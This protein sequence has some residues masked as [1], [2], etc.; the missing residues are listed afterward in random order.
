MVLYIVRSADLEMRHWILHN[1]PMVLFILLNTSLRYSSNDKRLPDLIP[2]C[3]CD[4]LINSIVI[5]YQNRMRLFVNFSTELAL[6]SSSTVVCTL[7]TTENNK[8]HI[9]WHQTTIHSDYNISKVVKVV[10][11]KLGV[12]LLR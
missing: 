8:Q 1:G 11:S 3:F 6:L 5:N 7:C 12:L 10:V 2:K 9:I 4:S